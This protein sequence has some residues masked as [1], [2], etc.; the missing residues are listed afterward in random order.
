M[1][2]RW[3]G[4]KFYITPV[5]PTPP[6]PPVGNVVLVTSRASL[7]GTDFIDW[8]NLG[9]AGTTH[10]HPLSINTNSGTSVNVSMTYTNRFRR[11]DQVPL[12]SSTPWQ[13]NF[14]IGDRLLWT[15]VI[16]NSQNFLSLQWTTPGFAGVGTQIQ[17]NSPG[18]FAA[19]VSAYDSGNTLIGFFDVVGDSNSF[20]GTAIFIGIR[21]TLP[22][23]PIYRVDFSILP[24]SS[25]I[26]SFAINRVELSTTFI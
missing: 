3:W 23:N 10:P 13:G 6:P 21:S 14:S 9:A 19:R 16:D 4:N 2:I 25:D 20:P 18:A 5:E 12:G 24:G 8:G 11:R 15:N 1:G 22:M 26:A 7:I 17:A